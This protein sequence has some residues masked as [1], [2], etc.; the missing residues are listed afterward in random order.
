MSFSSVRLYLQHYNWKELYNELKK[1]EKAATTIAEKL[2][3]IKE[4]VRFI[5]LN[6][7]ENDTILY[8]KAQKVLDYTT[9]SIKQMSKQIKKQ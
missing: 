8:M 7:R 4:A 6:L 9:S 1:D 5:Q 3:R 2:R